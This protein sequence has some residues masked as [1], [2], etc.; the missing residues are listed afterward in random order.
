M[1]VAVH[2]SQNMPKSTQFIIQLIINQL[3]ASQISL[4]NPIYTKKS[5]TILK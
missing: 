2:M 1:Q 4:D 5:I 3:V